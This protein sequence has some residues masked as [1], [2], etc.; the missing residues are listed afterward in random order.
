MRELASTGGWGGGR[1]LGRLISTPLTH[2]YLNNSGTKRSC[3]RRR[4]FCPYRTLGP[5]L[6]VLFWCIALTTQ[7]TAHSP[8]TSDAT[9]THVYVTVGWGHAST[10]CNMHTSASELDSA[11][12][13]EP[14]IIWDCLQR[15]VQARQRV[16]GLVTAIT[17]AENDV[18]LLFGV[19]RIIAYNTPSRAISNST[20]ATETCIVHIV[21]GQG[22]WGFLQCLGRCKDVVGH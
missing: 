9:L 10:T 17:V 4:Q 6:L 19:P 11:V 3:D 2:V 18:P 15:R 5:R 12:W 16:I 8:P 20:P 14:L 13:A 21:E 7:S 22:W 1:L